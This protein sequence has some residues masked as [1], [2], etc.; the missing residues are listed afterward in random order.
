MYIQEGTNIKENIGTKKI[1]NEQPTGILKKNL[2]NLTDSDDNEEMQV[3]L[4]PRDDN[5]SK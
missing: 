4:E 2:I 3:D 5:I 1:A